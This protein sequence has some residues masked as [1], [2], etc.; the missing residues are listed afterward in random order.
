MPY[1]DALLAG[2]G[3]VR[4]MLRNV[5]WSTFPEGRPDSWPASLRTA[6]GLMLDSSIAMYI[7][8]GSGLHFIDNDA[9]IGICADRHPDALLRPLWEVWPDA[10]A[11]IEPIFDKVFR[12]EPQYLK[13]ME[14]GLT[15]NGQP[16]SRWFTFSA[17]P[18]RNPDHAIAGVLVID[19]ET[20]AQVLAEQRVM[21]EGE[22]L[23]R[24]FWQAPG[25]M[26]VLRGP[27]HVYEMA[28]E[29]YLRLIG[30]REH[31]GLPVR[32]VLP[33]LE[34]QGYIELLDEVYATGKVFVGRDV[35]AQF[36]RPKDGEPA[37]RFLNFVYQPIIE[38]DGQ[39]TGIF[40][41]GNDITEQHLAELA[42]KRLNAQ[43]EDKIEQLKDADVRKD[44][45]LAM[46]AHELRN[47]LAPISAASDLL[48]FPNLSQDRIRQTSQ[49][50]S[51]QARHMTSLIDDLM[52]V[53]RVTRGMVTLH[54]DI[55]DARLV[56]GDAVEQVR[57]LIDARRHHLQLHLPPESTFIL[58][59]KK[60]LVQVV[61]N[62]LN[63][64]AK[65]T[66]EGGKL[67]LKLESTQ[68]HVTVKVSDNGIGMVP[69]LIDRAFDLFA[70]AD[71]GADR[72]GGGLGLGLALVRCLVELHGGSVTA[73]SD[74]LGQG[75]EFCIVLPRALHQDTP[76][77]TAPSGGLAPATRGL[78]I[79][80][81][82]DNVDA[83][84]MLGMW[85]ESAGHRVT[86]EHSARKA[87]DQVEVGVPD[88][89]LLDIGLPD[90]D[91][92]ELAR[93]LRA[94]PAS[95]SAVLVAVTGY[96]QE[97]DRERSSQAGFD[98]HIVKP[99]DT[100]TLLELL[101]AIGDG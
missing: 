71:R 89:F 32:Q 92:N 6:V 66:P 90:I 15:Q 19:V 72:A 30:D 58:G 28:N 34:R 1:N 5:D 29:A 67:I 75:S 70:Q 51:R 77:A 2:S 52:D 99:V 79:M 86:I 83:A 43:L 37:E 8:W 9:Y 39:I 33:E 93:R 3:Q 24:L 45:F 49:I 82:D 12:G 100:K 63:N 48:G 40:I 76:S 53:S 16:V 38:Q 101:S 98:H 59:D 74:G 36:T 17:T 11:G 25:F 20:T 23:R 87:L 68:E 18:I 91:G 27:N 61:A 22:K 64:A 97:N 35:P 54:K 94:R 88:V 44:E 69:K 55:V 80:V 78:Q 42:S 31:I 65:Y 10:R 41:E 46:L 95:A 81:V 7:V 73:R 85:L 84:H 62:L 47:P 60:R 26:A 96:G 21:E 14:F 50:I 4:A 13:D 56:V 57:P